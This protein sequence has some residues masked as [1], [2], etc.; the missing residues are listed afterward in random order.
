MT[1]ADPLRPPI[2]AA[3]D[4]RG[5]VPPFHAETQRGVPPRM[6]AP[7]RLSLACG[8]YD[9][10]RGLIDGDVNPQGIDLTVLAYPTPPRQWQ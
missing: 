9:I 2:R 8:D 10:N 5:V 7:I 4:L 6:S 1:I 3:L